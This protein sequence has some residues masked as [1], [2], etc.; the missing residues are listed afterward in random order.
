M[1]QLIYTLFLR[2]EYCLHER[3]LDLLSASLS[4]GDDYESKKAAETLTKMK[5]KYYSKN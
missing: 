5:E 3:Q 2:L 4:R 1:C